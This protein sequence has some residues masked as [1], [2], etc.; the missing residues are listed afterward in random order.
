MWICNFVVTRRYPS[1]RCILLISWGR[2]DDS[3]YAAMQTVWEF[4]HKCVLKRRSRCLRW[5]MWVCALQRLNCRD[6]HMNFLFAGGKS[7]ILD[8]TFIPKFI[9]LEPVNCVIQLLIFV[10]I[11][12]SFFLNNRRRTKRQTLLFSSI[13]MYSMDY[14]SLELKIGKKRNYRA[15]SISMS[16]GKTAYVRS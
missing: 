14:K 10:Y 5:I 7:E 2:N 4:H 9:E 8:W 6:F 13:T 16:W 12:S 3:N 15:R 11:S 1:L